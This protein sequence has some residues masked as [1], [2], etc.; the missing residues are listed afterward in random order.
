MNATATITP[1]P[2]R[3]TLRVKASQERA[4]DVFVGGMGGWWIKGHSLLKSPQKDVLIEPRAGGRW[5]EVGE[6]GSEQ[7]WG[8][9]LG[10]ERP[11]RIVLAWQLNAEW[12]YDPDFETTVE[13]SFTPDGDHTIV[14]FEHRDL[15]RF[16]DKAAEVRG[17]YESGMDGG[18]GELL[19]GYQKE[20]EAKRDR[21]ACPAGG[22]DGSRA[23]PS[24]APLPFPP[25]FAAHIPMH[26]RSYF[27]VLKV[28]PAEPKEMSHDLFVR[29]QAYL[30]RQIEAGT[31]RLVGPVTDGG[32]I[33]GVSIIQAATADEAR[34]IAEGDPA[35]KEGV[36]GIEVHPA[37]F[38]SLDSLRIEYPARD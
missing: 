6:D 25:E 8:R 20:A 11:D 12:T 35:V 19:A 17:D 36:F 4:F 28:N 13:V 15:E 22:S 33:R 1:A 3:K 5:Y 16:G 30:R 29:H 38:P 23:A 10:W 21:D 27:L 9:V 7:S 26:V 24:P 2:I 34:A 32:R 14:E 18:W 31:Y 37:M